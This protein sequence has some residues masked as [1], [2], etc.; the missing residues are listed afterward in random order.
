MSKLIMISPAPRL[1]LPS[2]LGSSLS[3]W[4]D[5]ADAGTIVLN[6]SRVSEWRDKSGNGHMTAPGNQPTL[7]ANSLNG[8]NTIAFDN[9]SVIQTLTSAYSYTGTNITLVSLA[10]SSRAFGRTNFPR[11]WSMNAPGQQDFD[12][13]SGLL[14][15]YG[16]GSA[17]NAAMFRNSAVVGQ[18]T[19]NSNAQWA[20]HVGTKSGGSTTFS[21][22]GETRVNGLTSNSPLG[23]NV[24]RIGNDVAAVDSGLFGNVAE[25]MIFSRALNLWEEQLLQGHIAHKWALTASLPIAHPFKNRPPLVTDV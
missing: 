6:G 1:F 8:L 21:T 17:N 24:I 22:N 12:N 4:L 15:L 11:L 9:R 16:V 13:N 23:F 19:I 20:F 3:V 14:M 7:A 10:Y 25:N 5:A 2:D 18:S